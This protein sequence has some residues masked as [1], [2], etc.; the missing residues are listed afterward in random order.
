MG[1]L[2]KLFRR[3][4]EP[5][6]ESSGQNCPQCAIERRAFNEL[7]VMGA[8]PTRGAAKLQCPICGYTEIVRGKITIVRPH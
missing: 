3:G 1:L 5:K 7:V 8:E 2:K 4:A 6:E